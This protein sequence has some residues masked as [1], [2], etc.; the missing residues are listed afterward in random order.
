MNAPTAWS[1]VFP[2]ANQREPPVTVHCLT[3]PTHSNWLCGTPG[4]TAE[5]SVT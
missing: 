3:P 4:N 1:Q 5:P 2:L